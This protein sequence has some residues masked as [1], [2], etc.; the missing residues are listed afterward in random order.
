M[1][2]KRLLISHAFPGQTEENY[3]SAA[4]SVG[5]EPCGGYLPEYDDSCCALLLC[6]GGDISPSYYGEK[7][8]GSK[9]IDALRD[10]TEFELISLFVGSKKPILGI[11]RGMQVINVW[12]GGNL[13]QDISSVKASLHSAHDCCDNRHEIVIEHT[14]SLFSLCSERGFVN[15]SHHQAVNDA[16]KGI[17]FTSHSP[18]G[19]AESLEHETLPILGVQYHP[20]RMLLDSTSFDIDFSSAPF[21]WLLEKCK[22]RQS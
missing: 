9:G 10:R 21:L 22:E 12:F 18:D 4:R 1:S 20:E 13:I 19:T 6:G 17:V 3:K 11:C 15:S 2:S 8:I 16:G 5:F 14:S 7:N